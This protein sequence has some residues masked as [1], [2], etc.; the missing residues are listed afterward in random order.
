MFFFLIYIEKNLYIAKC[1]FS[2][3]EY[4]ASLLRFILDTGLN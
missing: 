3:A 4:K 2:I 1:I